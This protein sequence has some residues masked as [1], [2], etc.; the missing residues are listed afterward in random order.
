VADI[1]EGRE[2]SKILVGRLQ[3]KRPLGG[4]SYRRKGNI[5]MKLREME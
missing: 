2:A 4:S 5:S 3:G 1:G